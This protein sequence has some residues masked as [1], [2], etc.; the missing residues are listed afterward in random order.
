M[1]N[2]QRGKVATALVAL[3]TATTVTVPAQAAAQHPA[4]LDN[5]MARLHAA[6]RFPNA[7]GPVDFHSGYDCHHA[8][9]DQELH[10]VVRGIKRLA[11]KRV[12]VFV[13]GD[14]MGRPRVNENGRA[15][16]HRHQDVLH[17]HDGWVIRVRT[18]SG[19]LV[20]STSIHSS[21]HD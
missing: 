16:L 10:V 13:H 14:L 11:G 2:I 20:A 9:Q 21:H 8:G 5:G 12:K 15:R 17:M 1:S 6:D 18:R 3:L 7:H 19:H 4:E